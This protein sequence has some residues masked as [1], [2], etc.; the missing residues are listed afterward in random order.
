MSIYCSAVKSEQKTT[1]SLHKDWRIYDKYPLTRQA[2]KLAG[3]ECRSWASCVEF[4][5]DSVA[6]G[7]IYIQVLWISPHSIIPSVFIIDT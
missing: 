5:V 6:L 4:M 3:T 1:K 2:Q 7:Q